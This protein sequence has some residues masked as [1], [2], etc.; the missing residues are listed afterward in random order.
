MQKMYSTGPALMYVRTI[1]EGTRFVGTAESAP[2]LFIT[3]AYEPIYNDLAGSMLPMD[4]MVEG[5]EALVS[6]VLTRWDEDVLDFMATLTTFDPDVGSTALGTVGTIMGQEDQ[7]FEFWIKFPFFAKTAYS[8]A[9]GAMKPGYH[10]FA[11]MMVGREEIGVGTKAN[12]RHI[13]IQCQRQLVS[14]AS[15][16]NMDSRIFDLYDTDMSDVNGIPID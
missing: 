2:N 15:P 16:T 11:S 10:F 3:R 4:R 13:M 1:A 12:R 9:P 6:A 7:T 14:G 5:H 8:S